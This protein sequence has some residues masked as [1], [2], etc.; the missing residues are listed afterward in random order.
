[1][2][3]GNLQQTVVLRGRKPP[4][5]LDVNPLGCLGKRLHN[6]HLINFTIYTQTPNKYISV[7]STNCSIHLLYVKLLLDGNDFDQE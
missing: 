2:F 3:S 5:I 1:M 7:T 4:Q 6:L